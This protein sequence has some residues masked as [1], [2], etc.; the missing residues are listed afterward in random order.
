[1]TF[2]L[3]LLSGHPEGT[4]LLDGLIR[5]VQSDA[6]NPQGEVALPADE[7]EPEWLERT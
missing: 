5:Y 7:H 2:G 4:C 1:M 6:F 3:D